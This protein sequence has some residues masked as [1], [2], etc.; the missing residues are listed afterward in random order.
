MP[1]KNPGQ[2]LLENAYKL[3]TPD[4]NESY[5]DAFAATYD[6]DFA[7][8]LGWN[9]P[10]II[11]TMYKNLAQ[12]T[13]VPIA[14]IGCGTGLVA[15]A[16]KISPSLID[17]MDI[18]PQMLQASKEKKLYRALY[19]ID[20]TA[21]LDAVAN[22]YGAV[23]SAGTFTHG[24]LGPEPLKNLLHIACPGGLFVIGVNKKH[25][26]DKLFHEATRKMKV[27][28]LISA[29]QVS[30]VQMYTKKGHDHSNDR[31]LILTYRKV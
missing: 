15:G 5:Y 8:E 19:K 26:D 21:S 23:L 25:F 28:G 11:A 4:D 6:A 16:L 9:Y 12:D 13:D 22:D 17:G 27:E 24:H 2:S 7:E 31:C 10:E 20:L 3:K 14:D 29:L 30:E 1:E 18:S